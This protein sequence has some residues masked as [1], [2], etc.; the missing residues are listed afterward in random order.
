M[1]KNKE[2][3]K[4]VSR[5]AVSKAPDYAKQTM[6]RKGYLFEQICSMPNLL[7]AAS[8]ASTGKRKRKEV[9]EFEADLLGNLRK[10]QTELL[11]HSYT[12][13]K[14]SV[15]YKYE[16]KLREILKLPYRDRV[17]QWAI[18]QVL[19]PHWVK[20]FT[21]D[22]YSCIKGRGLHKLLR[23]M[24]RFMREDPEGTRYC[25]K[26]DIRKF[27][28][29]IDH[30]ILKQ[31]I[32]KTIKDPDV[33]WLLDDIIDSA[34]GVPIGN[35]I[36]SFFANLYASEF[37]HD[38]KTLFGLKQNAQALAAYTPIYVERYRAVY[39]DTGETEEQL[40]EKFRQ[41]VK[42]FKYYKR[43]A[44]DSP[45]FSSDKIFLSMLYDWVALYYATERHLHVKDNWQI[46]PVAAR[47]VDYVGYVTF[48]THCRARKRNKV[49]LCRVVAKLRK[50]GLTSKEIR[51]R[52]ASRLGFMYHCDSINLLKKL[53]MIEW[54]DIDQNKG[55]ALTGKKLNIEAI[56]NRELH[57]QAY[58]IK[59][60][61]QNDGNCLTIQ[62]EI[63][64]QLRDDDGCL[65]WKD[66]DGQTWRQSDAKLDVVF[67]KADDGKTVTSTTEGK[68]ML[69]GWVQHITFTGSQ[70]LMN[71]LSGKELTEA[72]RC[73][74]I[75][76]LIDNGRRCFY[77]LVAVKQELN[78]HL[79]NIQQ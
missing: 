13:S 21:T 29:S 55:T 2:V 73:M 38:V 6:K 62:Y 1:A 32:R 58:I 30:A 27:Y 61:K 22:T 69:T 63:L 64:E 46:F 4:G 8:N 72:V 56:L 17:V 59:P 60:S 24:R 54:S 25:L 37:D 75:K 49:E 66:E 71:Q 19:E 48:H 52:V 3:R 20:N 39:G 68:T 41:A 53:E 14:Y 42:A 34:D 23:D 77:K 74:I 50:K 26:I 51:L 70:N 57:L 36:S 11:T 15:F 67:L 45:F 28:P 76:Q 10:I 18:V 31:V 5:A 78:N 47:G 7:L 65:L 79:N 12:T 16:P 44:D 40:G 43:Y 35:Y 9:T 33:L